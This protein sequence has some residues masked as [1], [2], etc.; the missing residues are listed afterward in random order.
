M[1]DQKDIS[2]INDEEDGAGSGHNFNTLNIQVVQ[3][4][5][6][7]QNPIVIV[8]FSSQRRRSKEDEGAVVVLVLR[9]LPVSCD[10]III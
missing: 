9:E 7:R 5:D 8:E 10:I 6:V 2:K 1:K 4:N 3:K